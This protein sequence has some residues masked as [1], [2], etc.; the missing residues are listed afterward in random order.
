[1]T[2][3]DEKDYKTTSIV[4]DTVALCADLNK[5]IDRLEGSLEKI[6]NDSMQCSFMSKDIKGC[7]CNRMKKIAQEAGNLRGLKKS[8]E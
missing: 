2:R 1:M 3:P 7:A 4:T 6:K 8:H 5:Y